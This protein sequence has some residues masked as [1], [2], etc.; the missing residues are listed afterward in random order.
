MDHARA[1][2]EDHLAARHF[3]QI[4]AEMT[5][6]HEED[7]VIGRHA[8]NDRLGVAG[9]DDP[10]G[11]GFD[12][13]GAVDVGDGLE[14]P[15]IDAE[16]FLIARQLVGGAAVGQAATGLQIRQQHALV[17]VENLGR[18]GHEMHAAK[19]DG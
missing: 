9:G 5:I 8:A 13:G 12:G 4:L 15:A 16:H 10:V 3:L 11:Q 19:D 6:R 18:L 2:P 7:L 14:T 1:V 17:G